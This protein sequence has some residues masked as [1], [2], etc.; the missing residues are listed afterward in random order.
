VEGGGDGGGGGPAALAWRRRRRGMGNS[1]SS[2]KCLTRLKVAFRGG[3][4][5]REGMEARGRELM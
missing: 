5:R 2:S 3:L 4:A 1:S